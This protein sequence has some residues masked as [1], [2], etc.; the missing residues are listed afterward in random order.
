MSGKKLKGEDGRKRHGKRWVPGTI[1][2]GCGQAGKRVWRAGPG[3]KGTRE[4]GGVLSSYTGKSELTSITVCNSCGDKWTS[5]ILGPLAAPSAA[6][7]DNNE[8]EAE[9]PT[10]GDD[11]AKD[12]KAASPETAAEPSTAGIT[13]TDSINPAGVESTEVTGPASRGGDAMDVDPTYGTQT[14]KS[15]GGVVPI[16]DH[17]ADNRTDTPNSDQILPVE[18]N[19]VAATQAQLAPPP[20]IDGAAPPE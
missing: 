19:G 2:E 15:Q 12:S 13:V 3:G 10:K 17:L 6:N 5:G 20:Q 8:N 18:S 16:P 9:A 14:D 4:S 1:C 7:K 11:K